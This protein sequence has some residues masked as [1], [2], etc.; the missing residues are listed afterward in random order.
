MPKV[1]PLYYGEKHYYLLPDGPA[2]QLA[3]ALL[4]QA[5]LSRKSEAMAQVVLSK[6]EQLVLLRIVDRK[7]LVMTC[8]KY[9]DQVR[10]PAAFSDELATM[11]PVFIGT[12]F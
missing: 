3:Y 7:L 2:A 5:M 10:L 8:L 11:P 4:V 6:R 1:P 12:S 9:A